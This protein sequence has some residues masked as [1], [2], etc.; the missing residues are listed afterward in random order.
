MRVIG[1]DGTLR[2]SSRGYSKSSIKKLVSK[3]D[4]LVDE[5]SDPSKQKSAFPYGS[6]WG[7]HQPVIRS[8][9]GH[10]EIRGIAASG[11]HVALQVRGHGPVTAPIEK[12]S[13]SGS[14]EVEETQ[15][16]VGE[17]G[18][19]WFAGPLS[20]GYNWVRA[21]NENGDPSW[22]TTTPSKIISVASS[23]DQLW[24][25]LK[26][27]LLALDQTGTVVHNL[28]VSVHDLAPAEDGG[29]WAVDGKERLRIGPDGSAL[30]RDEAKGSQQI[31]GD[32]TWAAE[33]ITELIAGR[34]G[35]EGST[36]IV[37]LNQR[38]TIVGLDANGVAALRISLDNDKVPDIAHADLD[39][40]GQ[41]ELLI[42]SRGRGV[43][44]VELEIP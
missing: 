8:I 2:S 22:F 9:F 11:S 5:A 29:I 16:A 26:D 42:S 14:L 4:N 19:A 18:I 27:G 23:G 44:T 34:F 40:D 24:V 39:G 38:N 12:G 32:G 1:A 3:L 30:L 17:K 31:A 10:E 35:P 25:A 36:R 43:A 13:I 21:R 28:D 33:G 41:D 7:E 15:K 20:Y 6:A 37:G